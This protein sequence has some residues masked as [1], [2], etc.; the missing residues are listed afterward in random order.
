MILFLIFLFFCLIF[1]Q[2]WVG[3][4][5]Y[6]PSLFLRT[7]LDEALIQYKRKSGGSSSLVGS[8]MGVTWVSQGN[9]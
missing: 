1:L 4:F 7:K 6:V 8:H 5:S 9:I 2:M 3:G